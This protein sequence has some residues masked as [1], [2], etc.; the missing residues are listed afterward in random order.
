MGKGLSGEKRSYF[1][2][3]KGFLGGQFEDGNKTWEGAL[4]KTREGVKEARERAKEFSRFEEKMQ[5]VVS[6]YFKDDPALTKKMPPESFFLKLEKE[7]DS[8]GYEAAFLANYFEDV[9]EEKRRDRKKL[10]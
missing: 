1:N 10:H 3:E 6:E 7:L 8:F 2:P 5:E 4:E 9:V